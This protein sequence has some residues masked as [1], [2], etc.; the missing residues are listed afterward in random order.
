M[1]W[2]PKIINPKENSKI[3]I[4][5]NLDVDHGN[6]FSNSKKDGDPYAWINE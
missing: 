5:L 2:R 1:F 4:L 6:L 3:P